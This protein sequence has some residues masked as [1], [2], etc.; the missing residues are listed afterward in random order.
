[1]KTIKFKSTPENF[2]KEYIGIKP[3][4]VRKFNHEKDK[5]DVRFQ[6]LEDFINLRWNRLTIEIE[7]TETWEIFERVVTDVT[8]FDNYYIISW[9]Q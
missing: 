1:M 7:N 8:K 3:N 9:K 2:R 4:T 5:E 6:I